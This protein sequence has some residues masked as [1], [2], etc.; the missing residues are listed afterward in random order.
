MSKVTSD[1]NKNKR[2]LCFNAIKGRACNYGN[3]CMY[4]HS[5]SEQKIDPI[6]HK[7]YTILKNDDSLKNI[8]L[9]K[10]RRLF[11]TL[12]E[13]TKV[14]YACTK[15]E[16]HGGYNCRNGAISQK[17]RIC[18]DDLMYGNCMRPKCNGLHLTA[19]GLVP[20]YQQMNQQKKEND[21]NSSPNN[22]KVVEKYSN[23]KK[24]SEESND[25]VVNK[26][27]KKDTG[28]NKKKFIKSKRSLNNNLKGVLLTDNFLINYYNNKKKVEVNESDSDEDPIEIE[29]M[30]EYLENENSEDSLEE[31]IFEV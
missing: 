21:P 4:A 11:K 31:S 30:K 17:Y 29:K 27:E 9:I 20:Y 10:D 7:V 16:C 25:E 8:N 14:C 5:L 3:K 24:E 19:R 6:R 18:H 23:K 2:I 12:T 28:N 22:N 1:D 13:L 26:Q 15:N